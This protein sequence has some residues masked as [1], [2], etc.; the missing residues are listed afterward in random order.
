MKD[1]RLAITINKPAK[2]IFEFALNPKNTPT[3]VD[4]ITVEETNEWP[5]KLGTIYRNQNPAGE[6]REYELTAFKPNKEF[7]L[8]KKGGYH[9][10]YTL[11]PID[12]NTTKLEYYEWIDNGELTEVLTQDVLEKLKR[13]I[14]EETV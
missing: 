4:F 8:S 11:R 9:V 14:E 3:W 1:L 13:V 6:W 12:E 10:R 7:V 5:P 2:V